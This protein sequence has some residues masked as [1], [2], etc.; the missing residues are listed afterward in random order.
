MKISLKKVEEGRIV[1]IF[2]YGD[3]SK[4]VNE[5]LYNGP[6]VFKENE[7]FYFV[8]GIVASPSGNPRFVYSDNK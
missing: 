4:K 5:V 1:Q 3:P 6:S 2:I 7:N 8:A